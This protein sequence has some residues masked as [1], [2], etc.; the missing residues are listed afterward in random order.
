MKSNSQLKIEEPKQ[1]GT[2]EDIIK[3]L[4]GFPVLVTPGDY[5]GQHRAREQ[6][7]KPVFTNSSLAPFL[8]DVPTIDDLTKQAANIPYVTENLV[9]NPVTDDAQMK[10]A[11]TLSSPF[12]TDLEDTQIVPSSLILQTPRYNLVDLPISASHFHSPLYSQKYGL[13]R[14]LNFQ[15]Y[16]RSMTSLG[17]SIINWGALGYYFGNRRQYN[18]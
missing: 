3:Y 7:L 11:S 1:V 14:H 17:S 5:I 2:F 15:Q 10:L 13:E 4:G 18:P 12:I 16:Q 9:T 8:I 6:G